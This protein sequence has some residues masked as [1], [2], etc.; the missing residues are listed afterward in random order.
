MTQGLATLEVI[1]AEDIQGNARRVGGHLKSRLLELMDRHP[2]IGEVRGMGLM[3]GVE[4]V[5]DR[6]TKEPASTEAVEVLEACKERGLLVGRG[7]STA[8][9]SGSSRRCA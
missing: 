2:L 1:D 4:L 6:L 3:L 8:T 7:A 9:S 5:R